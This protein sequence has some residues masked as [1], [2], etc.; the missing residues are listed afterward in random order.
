MQIDTRIVQVINKHFKELVEPLSAFVESAGL[1]EAERDQI[2]QKYEQMVTDD[3]LQHDHL[4]ML[5]R[6]NESLKSGGTVVDG[7][8]W[9]AKYETLKEHMEMLERIAIAIL[10]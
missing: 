7:T 1:L 5:K 10:K 8:D 4:N 3:A 2:K 6:E 9:K